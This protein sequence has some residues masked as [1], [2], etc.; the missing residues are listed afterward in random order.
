MLG[1][2]L[3]SFGQNDNIVYYMDSLHVINNALAIRNH[4][5]QTQYVMMPTLY[6]TT[7]ANGRVY[8]ITINAATQQMGARY[9]YSNLLRGAVINDIRIAANGKILFAGTQNGQGIYGELLSSGHIQKIRYDTAFKEIA[10]MSHLPL[11]NNESM[12]LCGQNNANKAVHGFQSTMNSTRK[13]KITDNINVNKKVKD[14]TYYISGTSPS[15]C[16]G[17]M[18]R[19]NTSSQADIITFNASGI[20]TSP[21]CATVK[22]P[23]NWRWHEGGGAITQVS[24][25]YY[26]AALDV[27]NS[28]TNVDGVFFIK[29]YINSIGQ[30]TVYDTH[31]ISMPS[32]KVIVKDILYVN[33]PDVNPFLNDVS[34]NVIGQYVTSGTG[35]PFILKTDTTFTNYYAL[36][37]MTF[38]PHADL[39]NFR[40]NKAIYYDNTHPVVAVG[41]FDAYSGVFS[42]GGIYLTLNQRGYLWYSI[43]NCESSISLSS[44]ETS[45][46]YNSLSLPYSITDNNSL[47]FDGANY[48]NY[49]P[50][51]AQII[52]CNKEGEIEERNFGR[53]VSDE[54]CFRLQ[55]NKIFLENVTE[56]CIFEIY[57]TIGKRVMSGQVTNEINITSLHKGLY[58]IRVMNGEEVIRTDKFVR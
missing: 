16:G 51:T 3:Q 39:C 13:V 25:L 57:N 20:G 45:T 21:Q 30:V 26:V 14:I 50:S 6:N 37:Y 24:D 27:R 15:L 22:I 18:L 5:G 46:S 52:L 58:I 54:I 47:S 1:L 12:L 19:Y 11:T 40:L 48:I 8:F 56:G 32:P 29:F 36:E 38:Q 4:N 34:Y 2:F 10:A 33:E 23:T 55:E 28:I 43:T 49:T 7:I 17:V 31:I 35:L 42:T 53:R 44:P 41:A 9:Y